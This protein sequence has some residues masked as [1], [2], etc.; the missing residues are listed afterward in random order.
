MKIF[1]ER[2][3]AVSQG[4]RRIQSKSVDMHSKTAAL[5]RQ[6]PPEGKGGVDITIATKKATALQDMREAAAEVVHHAMAG[7]LAEPLFW[8]GY[9]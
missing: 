8:K 2:H 4:M 7:H 5:T 3:I 9:L 1:R 6:D